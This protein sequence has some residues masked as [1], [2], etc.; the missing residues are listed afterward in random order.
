[1][2]HRGEFLNGKRALVTG[3]A[4][5]IGLAVAR[6][7]ESAGADVIMSDIQADLLNEVA[8]GVPRARAVVAD[9][10]SRESLHRLSQAVGDVDIL[11]NN[12]G[13]QHV[14]PVE[15][16]EESKWDLL[17]A[18][19]LTAPFLLVQRLIPGMFARNWGRIVNVGSV[20]SLVAS[21]YKSAYVSAKHGLMGFTKSVALEAAARS[22]NV[23]VNTVCPSYVRTPL[24]EKQIADQARVHGISEDE[25]TARVLLEQNAQ[26]R[27][28]EPE[29]V[30]Q[31]VAFLCSNAAASITGSAFTMDAGWL[32]H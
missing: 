22:P 29:E 3:A 7:L 26:K 21:P 32:A 13:L 11:V 15:E 18:T 24:V 10:A 2:I 14:R 12:A 16:F 6:A 25:V 17:L 8:A 20:H 9:L 1:M 4:S 23:T 19:M 27:L 28:I 31:C 5:G 30:G